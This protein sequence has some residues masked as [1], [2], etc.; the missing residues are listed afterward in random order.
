MSLLE[1][2]GLTHSFGDNYLFKNADFSLNKGEHI[3]IVGQNGAG[4]STFIKFCT[5]QLIPD[6]GRIVWQ[7]NT[8][9]GYLDQY[10]QIEK[11]TTM[12]VFL[13][14]AFSE[15]Y[16]MENRMNQLYCQSVDGNMSKLD[17][18][19]RYQEEL[20][21]NEFYL[22]DTTCSLSK[23]FVGS[24][25][26][27]MSGFSNNN[28]ANMTFALCPPLICSIGL[29]S[30]IA[31]KPNPVV[32][33]SIFVSL[34]EYLS[35]LQNAFMV[36]SHDYEFLEKISTRICDIDN[37]KITKYFGTY[38]EFRRKKALLREDYIRQYVAQQ[39]TIK[40]TE[41]FI[42]KNI[43]G[44][45][46]KMAR[47]RQKQLDRMDKMEAIEQKE[48][49]PHFKFPAAPLTTTEHLRVKHL[50]VGYHYPVLSDINFSVKGGEKVV[51]T[52]FN[53]IGKSTMFK[54]LVNQIPSLGGNFHFSEQVKIGYFE[55]D[56]TWSD[57]TKTPIQIVSDAYPSL[58][59]KDVRKRLAGCGISSKHAMQE[60]STLSGGEQAKVKIC[61]LMMKP[62]NFLIMDEPTNHLDILAKEALRTALSEFEGTVIL[63]SHEEAFYRDWVQKVIN[64]EKKI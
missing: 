25:R 4:K 56:L 35:S 39:K 22:I 10:A 28:F 45:K 53:G 27:K 49:K 2:T 21:R 34:A 37:Q 24:S 51:I 8:K 31:I 32:T 63:V 59:I 17:M 62:C 33:C 57:T 52:G 9:I 36:V 26:S 18:A 11:S 41:E 42:R 43:A 5:E 30:P 58:V 46:S 61:L 7:P 47:G 15:L 64:V 44:R 38:Y 60:I 40:K 50:D 23:K 29:S 19:A 12:R 16:E 6:S 14:S 13:Q 54:T 55:Q 48:I 1:V 20:E 3:G